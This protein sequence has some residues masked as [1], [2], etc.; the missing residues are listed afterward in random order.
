MENTLSSK[1]KKNQKYLYLGTQKW[2]FLSYVM[3][4]IKLSFQ[5]NDWSRDIQS[6]PNLHIFYLSE[7]FRGFRF[8]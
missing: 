1:K 5:R 3:P 6:F 7:C 2:Y 4:K 8:L